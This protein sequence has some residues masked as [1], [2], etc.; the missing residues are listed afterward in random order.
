MTVVVRHLAGIK[1]GTVEAV[2]AALAVGLIR[3]GLALISK[4]GKTERPA[5][6]QEPHMGAVAEREQGRV[7]ARRRVSP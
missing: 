1:A 6:R 4:A 5:E 7:T 2:P 3:A